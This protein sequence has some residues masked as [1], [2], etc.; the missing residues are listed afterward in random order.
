MLNGIAGV[1]NVTQR[2]DTLIQTLKGT[3]SSDGQIQ[4]YII[5]EM[6]KEL[7][8]W[9]DNFGLQAIIIEIF[10]RIHESNM[11]K[12][13]WNKTEAETMARTLWERDRTTTKYSTHRGKIVL[14]R[15]PDGKIMKKNE[16]EAPG[17]P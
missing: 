9:I 13:C 14:M 8:Q 15:Q 5:K 1:G 17:V 6:Q 3:R 10:T 11:T 12:V 16:L 4:T 2:W 7:V